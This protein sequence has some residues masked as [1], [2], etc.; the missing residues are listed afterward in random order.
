MVVNGASRRS[1]S[2]WS[3]H[4]MDLRENDYAELIEIRG[5]AAIG[6]KDALLEM[7]EDARHTR[8]KN[9]FYQANFNPA[10]THKLTEDQWQRAF[11]I[12][13]K[14]RGIPDGQARIVYE[15]EKHGRVHRH[16]IWAR[17]DLHSVRAWPDNFD[18]KICHAASR[19][20]SE[21][22]GLT[23]TPSP[24]DKDRQAP[25]PERAPKSYEMFRGQKSGID[26]R[27]MK[28]DVTAIFNRSGDARESV[29][30]L[31]ERG[32]EIV[33]GDRRDYCII[34]PTGAVHS[35]SRR[36]G[37]V[38]AKQLRQFME[39]FERDLLPTISQVKEC[40]A[41]HVTAK[42]WA[43]NN[44]IRSD[45][46]I[47]NSARTLLLPRRIPTACE[48][49]RDEQNSRR[50]TSGTNHVYD[51]TSY[52]AAQPFQ[53]QTTF[54]SN[55]RAVSAGPN[56]R[57]SCRSFRRYSERIASRTQYPAPR[58]P[59][60]PRLRIPTRP[61][62]TQGRI[63]SQNELFL[64]KVRRTTDHE[65]RPDTFPMANHPAEHT[66]PMSRAELYEYYKRCGMLEVYFSLYPQ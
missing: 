29:A 32:F 14:H 13:E 19:A 63:T 66:G 59:S 26:P 35:L 18:A 64:P 9:F 34:D 5:L 30:G 16:V 6:L 60:V 8:C 45:T 11:E 23:R 4:L 65:R 2:F 31:R 47:R 53:P 12:F 27:R 55:A 46:S 54:I 22:L 61:R 33:Q 50:V 15:H 7:Q 43:G 1:V 52:P 37:G 36:V 48:E 58:A 56:K 39:G 51:R 42:T 28:A 25:R 57:V 17:T 41:A 24:F 49:A 21:E 44:R 38:N 10:P 20:I 40:M 62:C 3:R